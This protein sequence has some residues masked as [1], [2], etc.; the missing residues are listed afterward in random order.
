LNRRS[1]HWARAFTSTGPARSKFQ[2]SACYQSPS[3]KPQSKRVF[4]L[5]Q[6]QL[7][8]GINYNR[9]ISFS[10]QSFAPNIGAGSL[11]PVATGGFAPRNKLQASQ[12]KIR[13]TMNQWR[14]CQILA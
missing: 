9:I 6:T 13:N 12:I 8:R 10:R 7:Q 1:V 14:F 4:H 5:S 3:L 2:A 11:D